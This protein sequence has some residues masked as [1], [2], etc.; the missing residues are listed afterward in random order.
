MGRKVNFYKRDEVFR[1]KTFGKLTAIGTDKKGRIKCSCECGKFPTYQAGALLDGN[2]ECC[3]CTVGGFGSK[4]AEKI[5]RFC[6]LTVEERIDKQTLLC[7]CD[8]GNPVKTRPRPLFLKEVTSCKDCEDDRTDSMKYISTQVET[9]YRKDML[10]ALRI[11]EEKTTR[12]KA[13][14]IFLCDC[15]KEKSFAKGGVESLE[16]GSCGCYKP[17]PIL[18]PNQTT[19]EVLRIGEFT[20][21]T[22]D[23]WAGEDSRYVKCTCTCGEVKKIRSDSLLS[24]D[25]TSCGCLAR[26]L[27][28]KRF[29]GKYKADAVSRHEMYGRYC[30]IIARCFCETN[31]DY[32][33]YGGRGITVCDRWISPPRDITGFVNFVS[34]MQEGYA[35]HLEIERLDKDGNY[36]PDN[37]TWV[38][39]R[40][41]VNN[42]SQNRVLTGYGIELNTAEWG[43][44]L[45]INPKLIDDRINH[46]GWEDSLESILSLTFRDRKHSL[47][48]KGQDMNA[49]EIFKEEGF[50]EGQRNGRITKY[51][52]SVEALESLGVDFKVIQERQKKYL[53]FEEGLDKLRAKVRDDYED[54]L[55]YKINE[56][57]KESL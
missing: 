25:S 1:I 16:Y 38:N 57:Q 50:T 15:G 55:L 17:P 36:C 53:T 47:L 33:H 41:Q 7:R 12:A 30:G 11:D 39:R 56:Q 44:L 40:S 6:K 18:E 19:K 14:G 29:K 20:R 37:C 9:G 28:S 35:K 43:Y 45:D 5:G 23:S 42:T 24:G 26:E 22:V 51:G 49:S 2:V 46:C 27:C 48:Y 13:Y 31:Q 21:W 10:V 8:C 4:N 54:H 34:D 52:G 3:G 32:Q